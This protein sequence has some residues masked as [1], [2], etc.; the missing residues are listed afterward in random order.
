MYNAN[1]MDARAK[2]NQKD[3]DQRESKTTA[4]LVLR[5]TYMKKQETD[6]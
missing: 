3:E 5:N 2:F 1:Q 6:L 4:L